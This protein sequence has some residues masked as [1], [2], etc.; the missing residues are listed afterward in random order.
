MLAS[1]TKCGREIDVYN[2]SKV[3]FCKKCEIPRL[4]FA[5]LS[6]NYRHVALGGMWYWHSEPKSANNLLVVETAKKD[7]L[8][9]LELLK[10]E[11]Q[12]KYGGLLRPDWEEEI[13]GEDKKNIVKEVWGR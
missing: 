10:K 1:C 12:E 3:F 8:E 9:R 13:S 11:M 5:P 2:G 6:E 4:D 7:Y